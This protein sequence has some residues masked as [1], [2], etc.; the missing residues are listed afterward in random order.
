MVIAMQQHLDQ[1]QEMTLMAGKM[2]QLWSVKTE[3]FVGSTAANRPF[4]LDV[5]TGAPYNPYIKVPWDRTFGSN[6][7]YA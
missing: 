6:L 2:G 1:H 4:C 3:F 5:S 7:N